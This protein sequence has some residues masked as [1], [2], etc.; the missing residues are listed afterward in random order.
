MAAL[1]E[2]RRKRRFDRTSEPPGEKTSQPGSLFVVQKHAARRLHYDFRLEADRTLKSW[3]VPKGPSLNPADKRLAVQTEDH[4]LEYGDF[5]GLIPEGNYGAGAVMVWDR[6]TYDVAGKGPAGEQLARGELKFSLRGEKLRGSF[7]LVKL[8]HSEK[9]NEWLLIKHKDAYADAKWNIEEHDGSV[10]TGRSL[11]E[12]AENSPP[13]RAPHPVRP[14]ELEGSRKVTMPSRL[15]PMLAVSL[16]QPFSDPDWLFEIKWDGVRSLAWVTGGKVELRSRTGRIISKQY[17]ELEVLPE[18]LKA[19]QAILDGEIVV[20]DERGRSDFERLQERMHVNSPPP[21]LLSKAPVT[22][23]VFDLLYCDGYDLREAPLVQRKELLRRLL[24]VRPQVRYCDHQAEQGKELFQLAREQGL[25]GI[26]GKLAH[27]PYVSGRSG[28]WAKL[29]ARKELDAVVGGWTAPRGSREHFGALLLGLYQGK[30]LRFIGHVGGGFDQEAQKAI[31]HQLKALAA[32][33]CP[34]DSVPETNEEAHW[35]KPKLVARVKYTEWTKEP[36]LR[37]PVF[38]ALQTEAKPEDCQFESG[39]TEGA[40]SSVPAAPAIV[41]HVITRRSE[42]EAELFRGKAENV[43]IE[44]EGNRVRLSNLNKIYFPQPRYTKRD[45]I[46]YYYRIA[47][48]L[49][50]FLQDR[51]LVL[52]R[53]PDGITGQSFFQKEAGEA[54]PD[55]IETVSIPSEEKRAEIRYLVANNVAALLHLTNLGCIDHNPWSSRRDD[56]EHPDYVFF[57]LDPAE[58]TDF[59][60]VVTVARALYEKLDGLG[61]KVFLKTSG[62]TGIHL[63]VPVERAYTYEQLRTFAEIVAR[64]VATE[65]PELVTQERAVAK[66]PPGK[67]LIDVHQNA[68]GR[69]LAA[70][71]VVR[72][73]PKAPISAPLQPSELRRSLRLDKFNMKTIF[74]RLEELGDLWSNFWENRQKLEDALGLLDTQVPSRR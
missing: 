19:R 15:E 18:R 37:Q 6:G 2:Y 12:I 63:Y 65:K 26:I 34:F 38:I 3:A 58:G 20:L 23:Y 51:P 44:L 30:K 40:S 50:P 70:P 29:K 47:D 35:V 31:S 24:D 16:D 11:D 8:R 7:A 68:F 45:L 43:V 42:I 22:Y 46:A 33:K 4:P 28:S 32:S 72:P 27:S 9:G 55:W 52:R 14:E 59:A 66:R 67:T 49:L 56:L 62:A 41:G 64:L 10:L 60:A 21:K 1:E 13:K 74:A 73:F 25:E 5:E 61:L 36:R 39:A 17:P 53:Y 57:D 71:Y 69:P 48:R 54:V